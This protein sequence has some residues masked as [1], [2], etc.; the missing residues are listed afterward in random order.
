TCLL[1]KAKTDNKIEADDIVYNR[2]MLE[3][4]RININNIDNTKLGIITDIFYETFSGIHDKNPTFTRTILFL[5]LSVGQQANRNETSK[6]STA[7]GFERNNND[8]SNAYSGKSNDR[9][10]NDNYSNDSKG[11]SYNSRSSSRDNNNNKNGNSNYDSKIITINFVAIA[12]DKEQNRTQK[13]FIVVKFYAKFDDLNKKYPKFAINIDV[14]ECKTDYILLL[15]KKVSYSE[16][17]K[18]VKQ[19]ACLGISNIPKAEVQF[20]SGLHKVEEKI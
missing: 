11:D 13:F 7:G 20:E 4:L 8:S 1:K 17:L 18:T 5:L 12:K 16:Y 9:S 15:N 14:V 6:A 10:A 19:Q 2:I 3:E